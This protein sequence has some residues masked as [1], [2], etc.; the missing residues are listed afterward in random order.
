MI[1][2][3]KRTVSLG[4]GWR[5]Q[6][7][8]LGP[9]SAGIRRPSPNLRARFT[10]ATDLEIASET[11]DRA[12]MTQPPAIHSVDAPINDQRSPLI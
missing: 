2:S 1:P 8:R 9:G 4:D 7:R 12:H 10:T 3:I 11:R 5:N 6:K